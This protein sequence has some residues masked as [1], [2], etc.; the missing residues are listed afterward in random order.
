LYVLDTAGATLKNPL[1]WEMS[2]KN[3][4]SMAITG[5]VFFII[6]ILIEYKI[7]YKPR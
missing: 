7:F 2:G 6:N 4:V 3:L 1:D 5:T